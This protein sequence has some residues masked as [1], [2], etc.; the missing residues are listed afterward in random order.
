MSLA[1]A[2]ERAVH[3]NV[4]VIGH[5]V[6]T[7]GLRQVERSAID[8]AY[9]RHFV[10][11]SADVERV[12]AGLNREKERKRGGGGEEEIEESEQTQGSFAYSSGIK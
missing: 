10:L 7:D 9:S 12:L 1:K 11:A 8:E 4:H 2:C 3:G 6:E 5:K